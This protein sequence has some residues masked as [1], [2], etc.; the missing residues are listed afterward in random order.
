MYMAKES[1]F[2]YKLDYYLDS[3]GF[4]YGKLTK[5]VDFYIIEGE[6]KTSDRFYN[7]FTYLKY[8]SLFI[9]IIFIAL[10]TYGNGILPDF[11]RLKNK[12]KGV[13]V[14]GSK[15]IYEAIKNEK[16]RRMLDLEKHKW[17]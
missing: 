4:Y 11:E 15:N 1:K 3:L 17:V 9:F 12:D 14:S 2:L 7:P 13:K 10:I 16:K 6:L 8:L 5:S